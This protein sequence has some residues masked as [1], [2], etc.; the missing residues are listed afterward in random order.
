LVVKD[1]VVVD[2]VVVVPAV[3]LV[4]ECALPRARRTPS[5]TISLRVPISIPLRDT[6]THA[7]ASRIMVRIVLPPLLLLL[8]LLFDFDDDDKDKPVDDESDSDPAPRERDPPKGDARDRGDAAAAAALGATCT[9]ASASS[10]PRATTAATVPLI[11]PT[12]LCRS[13]NPPWRSSS[14]TATW[15][16]SGT[17]ACVLAASVASWDMGLRFDV[18]FSIF[19]F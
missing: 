19:Q 7:A 14:A 12:V 15:R 8:L 18:I 6:A 9:P 2:V 3:A 4:P 10:R 13:S 5:S 1:L 16:Y 11:R 17:D